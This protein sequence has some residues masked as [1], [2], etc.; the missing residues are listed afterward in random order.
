MQNKTYYE[1]HFKN[2]QMFA[3]RKKL[4]G[5]GFKYAC[6][7]NIFSVCSTLCFASNYMQTVVLDNFATN[8]RV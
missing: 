8:N 4:L 5:C 3:K 1:N 2:V 6:E 7:G